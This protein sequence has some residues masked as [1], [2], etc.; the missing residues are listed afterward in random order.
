MP[1]IGNT[2]SLGAVV[3][4]VVTPVPVIVNM[5][6]ARVSIPFRWMKLDLAGRLQ[7]DQLPPASRLCGVHRSGDQD[8]SLI[9]SQH[10]AAVLP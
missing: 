4:N 9:L 8:W 1:D 6:E 3:N 2:H 7:D 10:G 5:G